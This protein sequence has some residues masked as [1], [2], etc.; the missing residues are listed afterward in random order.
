[1]EYKLLVFDPEKCIGC[2]NCLTVCPTNAIIYE[3]TS[4]GHGSTVKNTLKVVNGKVSGEN[5]CHQCIGNDKLGNAPCIAACPEKI[6]KKSDEGIT[7]LGYDLTEEEIEK[8]QKILEICKKCKDTPCIEACPYNHITIVPI[9]IKSEKFAVPVKC[10]Q[11]KGDPECVKWCETKAITYS[12]DLDPL[13]RTKRTRRAESTA[14]ALSDSR[15]TS[16]G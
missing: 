10:D 12:D 7:L 5:I 13:L 16:S 8:Y 11:C 2:G 9:F 3:P 1:M 4:Y 6:L 14:R 15:M